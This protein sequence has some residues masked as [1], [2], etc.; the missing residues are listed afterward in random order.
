MNDR[1]AADILTMNE[2]RVPAV[3]MWSLKTEDMEANGLAPGVFVTHDRGH[4][5]LSVCG[6]TPE[7]KVAGFGFMLKCADIPALVEELKKHHARAAVER[8]E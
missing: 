4:V 8:S 7:H 3:C 2:S 6:V 1:E 5:G